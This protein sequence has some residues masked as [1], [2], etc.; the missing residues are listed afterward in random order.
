LEGHVAA[1]E[2]LGGVPARHIRYDNLRPAVRQ[3]CFGRDRHESTRWVSFRSWF[4][5]VPVSSLIPSSP[6][7]ASA[8]A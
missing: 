5:H 2:A 7:V 3:V 8:V 6:L 4:V 1:F